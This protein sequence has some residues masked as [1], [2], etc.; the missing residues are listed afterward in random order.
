MFAELIG[1]PHR[2]AAVTIACGVLRDPLRR[3]RADH[4]HSTV[5]AFTGTFYPIAG[6]MMLIADIAL[7]QTIR[8]PETRDRDLV[9]ETDAI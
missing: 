6:Y 9:A 7:V 8:L 1:S 5:S 3:Y 2:Y 4:L